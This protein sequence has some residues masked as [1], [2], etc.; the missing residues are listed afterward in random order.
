MVI[1][2]TGWAG[3]QGDMYMGGMVIEGTGWAGNQGGMWGV[4]VIEGTGW[5][6]T[7]EVCGV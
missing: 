7:K 1:E 6:E 5:L 3:N 2:G 4:M